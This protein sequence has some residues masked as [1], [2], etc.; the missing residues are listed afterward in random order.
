[1]WSEHEIGDAVQ[2]RMLKLGTQSYFRYVDTRPLV[3][4]TVVMILARRWLRDQLPGAGASPCVGM[5]S[6]GEIEAACSHLRF[7]AY[8]D[9]SPMTR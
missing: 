6:L 5:L 2:L 8:I 7:T 4:C 1:M 3:P 9:N